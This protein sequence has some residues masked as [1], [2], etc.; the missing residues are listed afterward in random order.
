MLLESD[1]FPGTGVTIH[2]FKPICAVFVLYALMLDLLEHIHT[3]QAVQ[4]TIHDHMGRLNVKKG[5]IVSAYAYRIKVETIRKSARKVCSYK[6]YF[7]FRPTV[8]SWLLT[9]EAGGRRANIPDDWT[10]CHLCGLA[11]WRCNPT[12]S[13]NRTLQSEM[14]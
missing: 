9:L 3:P 8:N 1:N 7:L 2:A 14:I 4:E 13:Q 12:Y 11:L 5:A 10:P 6:P